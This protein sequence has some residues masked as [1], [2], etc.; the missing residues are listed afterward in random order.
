MNIT[1]NSFSFKFYYYMDN[2]LRLIFGYISCYKFV[3]LDY[4]NMFHVNHRIVGLCKCVF[5]YIQTTLVVVNY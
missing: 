2:K 3:T 5:V 1:W 4:V